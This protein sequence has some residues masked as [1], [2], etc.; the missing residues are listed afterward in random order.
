MVLVQSFGRDRLE[1]LATA[2]EDDQLA[3]GPPCH[4]QEVAVVGPVTED[5]MLGWRADRRRAGGGV[6]RHRLFGHHQR[7]ALA[8]RPG[9]EL[10]HRVD[11]RVG[12]T[13]PAC[14]RR[15]RLHPYRLA[16]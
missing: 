13:H 9:D 8:T 3:G 5:E 10:S 15:V 7:S 11:A 1:L 16:E 12:L 2:V 4:A 6:V 14:P